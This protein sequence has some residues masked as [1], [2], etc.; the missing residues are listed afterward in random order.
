MFKE[1]VAK[2]K[3][4]NF[5]PQSGAACCIKLVNAFG[6]WLPISQLQKFSKKIRVNSFEKSVKKSSIN[7]CSILKM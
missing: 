3:N 1:A 2:K 7:I 5:Q 4:Y 6:D